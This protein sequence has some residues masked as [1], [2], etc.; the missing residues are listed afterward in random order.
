MTIEMPKMSRRTALLG[1]AA[2]GSVSALPAQAAT[3]ATLSAT[4]AAA[5][6]RAAI[7]PFMYGGFIEH[8]GDL[9]NHSLW[10]EVLDDRKFFWPVN[11][12]PVPGPSGGNPM[13]TQ[14]NKWHPTGADSTVTMDT[15]AAYVGAHSPIVH[16]SGNGA[17]GIGQS[18]LVLARKAYSGRVVVAAEPGVTV[19]ATLIWGSNPDQRQTVT[20]PA[21][22]D[23]ST[24]PLAFACGADTQDGRLEITG[25]GNGSF[26]VGAV[27][28][29][30]ADNVGGFRADMIALM[31]EMD[32]HM[33]RMPGGNFI[34]AYD[35][36]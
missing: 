5:S 15:A 34:S 29:M 6:T 11:S 23:W 12:D 4:I 18:K 31:R 2:L 32:C 7:S 30:P 22:G 10:S 33:M 14:S 8:I 35:W 25:T 27:S 17:A 20:V 24:V 26:R 19:S 28:L 36:H 13:R 3:V 9:I 1:A 21:K 16:V